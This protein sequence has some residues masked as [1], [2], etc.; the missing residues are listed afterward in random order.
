MRDGIL[1]GAG[2]GGR[3]A[4]KPGVV[5]A[6]NVE[7]DFLAVGKLSGVQLELPNTSVLFL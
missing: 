1:H 4:I 2:D 6:M 3:E 7:L 5:R